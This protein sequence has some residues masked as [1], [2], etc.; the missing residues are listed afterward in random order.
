MRESFQVHTML[1]CRPERTM[2]V[3][4]GYE[5]KIADALTGDNKRGKSVLRKGA[6][7]LMEMPIRLLYLSATAS[8]KGKSSNS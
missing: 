2:R 1:I 8:C 7:I 3:G 6:R 4:V 5:W